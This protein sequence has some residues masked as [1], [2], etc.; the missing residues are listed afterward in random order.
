MS[1][2]RSIP[3]CGWLGLVWQPNLWGHPSIPPCCRSRTTHSFL[4]PSAICPT[5]SCP[6]TLHQ[7]LKI[8]C[9]LCNLLSDPLAK[10]DD[11]DLRAPNHHFHI[12][13]EASGRKRPARK[14]RDGLAV[15]RQRQNQ[16]DLRLPNIVLSR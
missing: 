11:G 6:R 13:E 12:A 2:V 1:V 9:F 5:N 8:I 14:W 3:P 15:D 4:P 10:E 16:E 7:H